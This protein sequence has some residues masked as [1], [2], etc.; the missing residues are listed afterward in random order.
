MS[1]LLLVT[2]SRHVHIIGGNRPEA[3]ASQLQLLW[4]YSLDK[5]PSHHAGLLSVTGGPYLLVFKHTTLGHQPRPFVSIDL[6]NTTFIKILTLNIHDVT[7]LA[8]FEHQV[9]L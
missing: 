2:F 4:Q 1:E 3:L 6:C 7:K 8:G 5:A 9:S